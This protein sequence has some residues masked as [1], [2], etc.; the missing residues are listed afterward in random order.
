MDIISRITDIIE[1]SVNSLGYSLVQIKLTES[2]RRK[3][4]T[5]MAE[6]ADDSIM[7][8][9]DCAK[10]SDTVSALLDVDDPLSGAYNLEVC[11]PGVDRPLIKPDDYSKFTGYEIK[12]E[13]IMP[14]E[15]RK[16]FRG[17]LQELEKHDDGY[18]ISLECDDGITARIAHDNIR[19]A[20][21]VMTDALVEEYLSKQNSEKKIDKKSGRKASK[22]LKEKQDN[23]Q[24]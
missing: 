18:A 15:R 11:S 13:T 20:K 21:L 2:A 12:L 24:I 5:I 4:L 14:I 1:P 19:F 16:R 9:D 8:F 22:K 10:I 23:V 17:I 6:K 3:T 7:G